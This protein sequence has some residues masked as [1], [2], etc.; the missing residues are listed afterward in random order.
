MVLVAAGLASGI[1]AAFIDI[2]SDWLGDLKTGVCR[3]VDGGGKFYLN[4]VFCCW[5]YTDL[6][7]CH[8]WNFW[9]SALGVTSSAG[10]WIIEYIFFV[11][12]SVSR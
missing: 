2:T 7:Q 5:G 6:S 12:F 4:R 9:S 1:I 8:D 10:S 11:G 3:N